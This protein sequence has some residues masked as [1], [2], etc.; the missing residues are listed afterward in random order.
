VLLDKLQEF[1]NPQEALEE[2]IV[3]YRPTNLKVTKQQVRYHVSRSL[4][5]L[6]SLIDGD[7]VLAARAALQ[8]HIRRP[9]LTPVEREGQSLHRVSGGAELA[10]TGKK[11]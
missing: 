8:K 10:E 1:S 7:D 9:V 2:Q 3:A 6:S 11:M 5:T 4:L